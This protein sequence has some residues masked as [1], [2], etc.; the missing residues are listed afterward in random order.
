MGL[1][2]KQSRSKEV[3]MIALRTLSAFA[4]L[5]A[6]ISCRTAR[7]PEAGTAV[8]P[9][10]RAEGPA[11]TVAA[12]DPADSDP[13]TLR[14][15]APVRSAAW[16]EPGA[17]YAACPP[18]LCGTQT[19]GRAAET[20]RGCV[21]G[22]APP[23]PATPPRVEGE[24]R[25][26]DPSPV[27]MGMGSASGGGSGR[28]TGFG[29]GRGGGSRVRGV[30]D[31]PSQAPVA[32]RM[33][34]PP[35]V[36]SAAGPGFLGAPARAPAD[37]TTE[38]AFADADELVV[39]S[40]PAEVRGLGRER[41]SR[42]GPEPEGGDVSRG[43]GTLLARTRDGEEAGEFP[44]E[45]TEVRA[46]IGGYIART[47][48][49]QRYRNPF[50]EAIEAVYVFPL[51]SLAAVND[52]VME[53]GG[54]R[55]VGLIRPRE[56]AE[57]IYREARA[58]GRTASLLT[59]ERPNIFTQNVANIEPGGRVDIR[60]TYFERLNHEDG[61]YEYVFPMVVGPR[62]IPGA[63]SAA[64]AQGSE[65][66]AGRGGGWSPPT[67]RV[68]D[69]DRI[70]P[71]VLAPGRRSGHDI[72]LVVEMD[73]G[74]PV[75]DLAPVTHCVDVEEF[76]ARRRVVTLSASDSIPNRDFVLRWSVAGAETQF[77]VLAH[78]GA[79][80]GFLTLMMQPPQA[81]SDE[82]VTPR[83]ISFII[84]VSGSQMGLPLGISREIVRR[85]LDDLRPEDIFNIYY[86]AS[87]NGQLWD[88]PRPRTGANVAEARR[89]LDSLCGG[90]GTE[91]LDG[92]RRALRGR[93]DPKY[94]QM[95]VF[96]TD[97]YVGNEEEIVRMVKEE[98][99]EARFFAFG[100]GSSVNRYLID[101]VAEHGGGASHVVLPRDED[102]SGK[103]VKR[104]FDLID[105]PVLVDVSV[106]WNGL[107]VEDVYP[108]RLS[109]LFAGQ[110]IALVAR[111]SRPARG[112]AYVEARVGARRVRLPVDVDL[113]G[114]DEAH[115]ALAPIWA[116]RRI[117]E[118][119]KEMLTAEQS[120]GEELKRAITDLAVEFRLVSQYTAFVAVDESRVVGDGRP[121]RILQPVEMPEGVSYEGVFGERPVGSVVEIPAWGVRL[122]ATRDGRVRIGAAFQGGPVAAAGIR[123]GAA[124]TAV[125][126]TAVHDLRHLEGLLLQS[127][128]TVRVTFDPGG[129]IDLPAP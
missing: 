40:A 73:A 129:D 71:P 55:I 124:V 68:P 111:Y 14:L 36:P 27:R 45:R 17:K 80:G 100:I 74:L 5:A 20:V 6:F 11:A 116:R 107:P 43:Q 56:E 127:G 28:T 22:S 98:R 15:V 53:I 94:L 52:F 12:P 77:G 112:T 26:C 24:H 8:G 86:F 115:A 120:R 57:R 105:S 47:V 102:H 85:A 67:D 54:R 61:R 123:E 3:P 110:T 92:I 44:L 119:S 10:P 70:T 50:G 18:A 122:Q 106:D 117:A 31:M 23:E 7:P 121:L 16:G 51:P 58:S 78:R 103:A 2:T 75:K 42:V 60:I 118:L 49:E 109:D 1:E 41:G 125:D 13:S 66:G 62:Y 72:G 96:F 25:H 30:G 88:E 91:M 48:V 113:P 128:R 90:G 64:P 114:T 35:T 126:R 104:L 32:H 69:A 21:E 38:D 82:Q 81:P 89:F 4:L 79:A 37:A 46:E 108:R 99:G 101:G 19:A 83:E 34:A 9:T 29:Y 39:V 33:M 93:H 65:S 76:G 95:Y 63:P 97:G 87:G 84:D 59:Q